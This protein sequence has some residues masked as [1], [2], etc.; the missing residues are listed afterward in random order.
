LLE[1][2]DILISIDP[3]LL[4]KEKRRIVFPS[5]F[6]EVSS[7]KMKRMLLSSLILS[8]LTSK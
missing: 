2:Q 8:S 6:E 4:I 3:V 1:R 5:K 7:G